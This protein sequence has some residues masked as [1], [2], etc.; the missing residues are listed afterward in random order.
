MPGVLLRAREHAV[1]PLVRPIQ[2][3][4]HRHTSLP[5]HLQDLHTPTRRPPVPACR[6]MSRI[7]RIIRHHHRCRNIPLLHLGRPAATGQQGHCDPAGLGLC[8]EPDRRSAF[9]ASGPCVAQWRQIAAADSAI[10]LGASRGAWYGTCL[11]LWMRAGGRCPGRLQGPHWVTQHDREARWRGSWL[12]SALSG[13][14]GCGP[15]LC[16]EQERSDETHGY[17]CVCGWTEPLT[18]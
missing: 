8:R 4:H 11:D 18:R 17:L 14:L 3:Q 13:G 7:C 1:V 2:F 15:I 9:G 16:A 6:Q 12:G 10:V 5:A